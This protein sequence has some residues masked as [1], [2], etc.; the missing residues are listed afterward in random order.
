MV[1]GYILGSVGTFGLLA[2]GIGITIFGFGS[3]IE[4]I[5]DRKKNA[6]NETIEK[7]REKFFTLYDGYEKKVIDEYNAKKEK[8]LVNVASYLNMCYYPIELDENQRKD[9]LKEYNNL[10]NS[11]K[12]LINQ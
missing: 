1:L 8:T 9:L 11:I 3:S 5:S 2:V 6:Y 10:E 7:I 12:N 4:S